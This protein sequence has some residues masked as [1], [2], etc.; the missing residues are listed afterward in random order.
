LTNLASG[1]READWV[2]AVMPAGGGWTPDGLFVVA[3]ATQNSLH[4]WTL[5]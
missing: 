2:P 4:L 3:T 1:I 5:K